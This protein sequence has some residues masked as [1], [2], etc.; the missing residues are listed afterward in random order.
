MSLSSNF[1]N[2]VGQL[3]LAGSSALFVVL[4][5]VRDNKDPALILVIIYV[6]SQQQSSESSFKRNTVERYVTVRA[7][8]GDM[9]DGDG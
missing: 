9:L 8:I 7:T 2:I 5:L 4:L 3:S 1:C 6:P